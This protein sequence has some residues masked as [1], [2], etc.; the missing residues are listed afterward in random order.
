MLLTPWR[1]LPEIMQNE[2]V[3]PYYDILRRKRVSL[4]LKRL[5]DIIIAL[6]VIILLSPIM[7]CAAV[8]V[9]VN[10]GG[11]V[12][13]RQKRVGRDLRE[14]RIFKFRTMVQNADKIGGALTVGEDDPRI[15][16]PGAFLRQTRIDEFPQ[17]FN[18]FIGDMS[19]VGT[20]PEVKKYVDKYTPEMLSTLLLAPGISGEASIAYRYENELL[21]DKEDPEQY[22]ID[23]VLPDKMAINLKYTANVGVWRDIMVLFRTVMCVFK[24]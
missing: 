19:L 21:K 22:Y 11:P 13:Y 17:L 4:F 3:K 24:K 7:L 8:A 9:K 6:I 5:G 1:K 12:F 20:R 18:V 2:A 23:T 15:T 16:K 10:D 14:I